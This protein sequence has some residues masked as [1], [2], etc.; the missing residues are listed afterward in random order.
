MA[1]ISGRRF[2]TGVSRHRST[3]TLFSGVSFAVLQLQASDFP[4]DYYN[5]GLSYQSLVLQQQVPVMTTWA[6][7]YITKIAY[8]KEY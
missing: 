2:P 4:E 1:L 3:L 5:R 6:Q 7:F 8:Y